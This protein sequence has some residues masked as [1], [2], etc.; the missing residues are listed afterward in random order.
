M[1]LYTL[2]WTHYQS[3]CNM[4]KSGPPEDLAVVGEAF[5]VCCLSDELPR[6]E[7]IA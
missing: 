4:A 5:F 3:G 2:S 7:C 1:V 6:R